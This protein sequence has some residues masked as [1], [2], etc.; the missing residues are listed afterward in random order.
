MRKLKAFR[1]ITH[2]LLTQNRK[3][4]TGNACWYKLDFQRL[5]LGSRHP[6]LKCAIGC[7]I[8]DKYYSI[9]L[10]GKPIDSPAIQEAVSLSLDEPVSS[11]DVKFL[12]RLQDIHDYEPVDDW[13]NQ[14]NDIAKEN[15]D[16]SLYEMEL[17]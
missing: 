9:D 10:E 5:G 12:K 8:D 3:S 6:E 16:Q 11:Y 14:L 1:R 2:H 15:W 13:K 4:E 7:L 17:A